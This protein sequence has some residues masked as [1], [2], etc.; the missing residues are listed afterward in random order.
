M[1]ALPNIRH[2]LRPGAVHANYRYRMIKLTRYAEI[3]SVSIGGW[4]S[5]AVS[6]SMSHRYARKN[7]CT[8]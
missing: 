6:A 1:P 4:P 8:R 5:V 3:L 7:N 2:G